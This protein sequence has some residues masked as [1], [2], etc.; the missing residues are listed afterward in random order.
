MTQAYE[1]TFFETL[2]RFKLNFN[3]FS[4]SSL[5]LG[6]VLV[7]VIATRNSWSQKGIHLLFALFFS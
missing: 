7:D 2:I 1:S 3:L 6:V 5:A 4:I